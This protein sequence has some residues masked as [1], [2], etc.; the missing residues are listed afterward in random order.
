MTFGF[1]TIFIRVLEHH[2]KILLLT[3]N[4]TE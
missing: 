3:Y 2:S 1:K 4:G